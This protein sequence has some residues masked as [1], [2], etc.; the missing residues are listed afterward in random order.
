MNTTLF[1]IH[2]MKNNDNQVKLSEDMG[3]AQ[4]ALN[5]RINGKM[6]FR[7]NEINFIRKRYNLSDQDTVEI[8]FSEEVSELDTSK[9]A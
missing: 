6:Q 1:K 8:F 7:Q 4:S 2:M 9:G 5:M 3:L